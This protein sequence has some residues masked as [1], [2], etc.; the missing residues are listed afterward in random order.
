MNTIVHQR[1][2]VKTA[3]LYYEQELTQSEIS[4][5]LGL[6]RQKVQRLLHEAREQGIV[7]INIRPVMGVYGDLEQGLEQRYGLDEAIIVETTAYD[8]QLV[9]TREIGAG[10]VEYLLRVL[11]PHDVVVVSWGG[12]LLGMVDALQASSGVKR[13]SG[14]K[15]VQ[16]LGGLGDP[17]NETHAADLTR[18]LARILDGRAVL[19]P[20]PGV[21]GSLETRMAYAGDPFVARSLQQGAAANLAFMGIGAPRPDSI[22][23]REGTIVSWPELAALEKQGAV[24]D[25]NLRYFDNQG[26]RV[27]SD[28]DDRVIGLTLDEI[29][30]IDRV[31][32]IAGGSA[33]FEAIRAALK[34]K[35]VDILVTDHMLAQRLLDVND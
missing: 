33:K 24:G 15:V 3:Q 19:L 5:R 31:V 22:L 23:C 4:Q 1:L 16:G 9:V 7:R 14:V 13:L 21:A 28:L 34:G 26:Q 35:L 6:S 32:G 29:R 25:I 8:N 10:A 27:A 20:A 18:R 12:S 30:Q 2:L 17:T 11:R